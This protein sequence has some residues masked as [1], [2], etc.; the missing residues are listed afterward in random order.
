MNKHKIL[1]ETDRYLSAMLEAVESELTGL[2]TEKSNLE[3]AIK[4]IRSAQGVIDRAS[5]MPLRQAQPPSLS[6]VSGPLRVEPLSAG[7]SLIGVEDPPIPTGPQ[8][9]EAILSSLPP[10]GDVPTA[11]SVPEAIPASTSPVEAAISTREKKTRLTGEQ[12]AEILAAHA[13]G[14]TIQSLADFWGLTYQGIW[15]IIKR[16]A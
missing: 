16:A 12:R 6:I 13:A 3:H 4:D 7:M 9:V 5:K 11:P 8:V 2:L 10:Q 15:K 1:S 14:A